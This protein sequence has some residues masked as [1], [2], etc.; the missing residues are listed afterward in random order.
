MPTLSSQITSAILWQLKMQ[1]DLIF[2]QSL[3]QQIPGNACA[4][5]SRL[6]QRLQWGICSTQPLASSPGGSSTIWRE[7]EE[8]KIPIRMFAHAVL[9]LLA[10]VFC[11]R[12]GTSAEKGER[13][14]LERALFGAEVPAAPGAVSARS[15]EG[16]AAGPASRY[17]ERT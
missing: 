3:L 6:A 17:P 2:R 5:A 1:H 14:R 10:W 8:K 15:R 12:T 4:T 11:W 7:G 16:R 13:Q 9:C